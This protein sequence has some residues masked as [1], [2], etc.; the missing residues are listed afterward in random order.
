MAK[1][2]RAG[3]NVTL[4]A[5]REPRGVVIIADGSGDSHFADG[6][7]EVARTL[8]DDG[9]AVLEV[10]LLDRRECAKDAETSELRFNTGLIADRL[11]DVLEWVARHPGC[12]DLRIG[13]YAAGT[14]GAGAL[15]AAARDPDSI[16]AIV[17]RATRAGLVGGILGHLCAETLLLCGESD[18]VGLQDARQAQRRAPPGVVELAVIDGGRPMLEAPGER[19]AVAHLASQWFTSAFSGAPSRGLREILSDSMPKRPE[20]RSSLPWGTIS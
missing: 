8:L 7:C 11:A 10:R 6:D 12:S 1:V 19:A 2:G 16:D 4:T 20:A 5:P 18:S 15:R 9:F 17:C 13:L 14:C 3:L